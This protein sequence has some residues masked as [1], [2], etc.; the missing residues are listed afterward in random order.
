MSTLTAEEAYDRLDDWN[1]QELFEKLTSEGLTCYLQPKSKS[2]LEND[3]I[4]SCET[5][6]MLYYR[7]D[8]SE[9]EQIHQ[10]IKKYN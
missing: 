1:K 5:L 8:N 3:F 7:M 4:K 9:I 10:L 6:S 2:P